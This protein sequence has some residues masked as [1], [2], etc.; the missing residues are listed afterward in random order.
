LSFLSL[1]LF[2]KVEPGGA[3]ILIKNII[4]LYMVSGYRKYES[5]P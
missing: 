1:I 5:G 3:T 2:W 4:Y